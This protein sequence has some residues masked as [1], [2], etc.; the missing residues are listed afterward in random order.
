[1]SRYQ[2]LKKVYQVPPLQN[3]IFILNYLNYSYNEL[4]KRSVKDV[5]SSEN[6]ILWPRLVSQNSHAIT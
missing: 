4:C 2:L 5:C 6:Y 1:M 3:I